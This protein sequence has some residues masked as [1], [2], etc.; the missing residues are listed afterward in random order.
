MFGEA[1]ELVSTDWKDEDGDDEFIPEKIKM[2]GYEVEAEFAYKGGEGSAN[3]KIKTFL[4][5]LTGRDGSG[6]TMK[7]YDAY[8]KIG[9]QHVRFARVGDDADMVRD[10]TSGDIILFTVVFK[11]NDPVTDV[12]LNK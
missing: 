10:E 8:T 11:V 6:A 9:R 4:N 5:Y 12:I 2:K 1:K 7:V 3:D